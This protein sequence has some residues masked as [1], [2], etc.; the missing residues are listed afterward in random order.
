MVSRV[1]LLGIAIAVAGL[2]ALPE[3]LALFSGQHNFYDVLSNNAYAGNGTGNTAIPCEKCHADI[4]AELQSDANSPHSNQSCQTCH[5]TVALSS[6]GIKNSEN[7]SFHAAA[8]PAC[9]DCH[10]NNATTVD[11]V[12]APDAMNIFNNSIHEP[13]AAGSLN[14]SLLKDANEACV[15]CHT[16]VAVNITWKKIAMINFTALGATDGSWNVTDFNFTTTIIT[17]YGNQTG[18][19]NSSS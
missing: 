8:D 4:A 13:F 7:G 2:I 9:L 5:M 11:N 3:T 18:G 16:H 19:I 6:E 15:A 10:G 14:S 1:I 17:T 12:S